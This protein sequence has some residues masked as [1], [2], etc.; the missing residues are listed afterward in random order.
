MSRRV[1]ATL[2]L[3]DLEQGKP[4]LVLRPPE[5]VIAVRVGD[6]VHAIAQVCSHGGASLFLGKVEG[7]CITCRAHGYTFDLVTGEA[8]SDEARGCAQR[9]FKVRR[10]GDV[11]EVLDD[12]G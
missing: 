6:D 4:V 8:L 11:L 5:H 9:V 10:D 1:L 12:D 7:R 3:G 2:R